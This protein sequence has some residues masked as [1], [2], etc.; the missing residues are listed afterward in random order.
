[1]RLRLI[2]WNL[3]GRVEKAADQLAAIRAP[4]PDVVALQEVTKSSWQRLEPILTADG[5]SVVETVRTIPPSAAAGKRGPRRYGLVIAVASPSQVKQVKSDGDAAWPERI[6]TADACVRD[7]RLRVV[8]AHIPPGSSNGWTKVEML[9][10]LARKLEHHRG[11]AT[12]FVGDLNAPQLELLGDPARI[13]TWAQRITTGGETM[14]RPSRGNRW[15][16]AERRLTERLGELGYRDVY[17]ELHPALPDLDGYSWC[18]RSKNGPVKRRFD[19]VFATTSIRALECGYVSSVRDRNLSDHC[20]LEAV[21][22]F[23]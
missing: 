18:A 13:I 1:M 23:T 10:A 9:E 20:A 7:T 5:W 22:D 8:T 16:D 11:R 17:R 21:F 3:A 6:L 2:S 12:V 15:D 19:H 4:A 14:M